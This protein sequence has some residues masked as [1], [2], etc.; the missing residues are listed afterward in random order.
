MQ[1]VVTIWKLVETLDNIGTKKNQ[2]KRA[3][4]EVFAL[5]SRTPLLLNDTLLEEAQQWSHDGF[6]NA[7]IDVSSIA[8]NGYATLHDAI[9]KGKQHS[10]KMY[11][12]RYEAQ[13]LST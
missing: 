2:A 1:H 3:L 7:M 13:E 11:Q 12:R 9:D 4:A 10:S 8:V 6:Q 5:I